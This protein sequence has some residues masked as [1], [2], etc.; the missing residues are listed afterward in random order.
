MALV[1]DPQSGRL[2]A[3][4]WGVAAHEGPGVSLFDG[5]CEAGDLRGCVEKAEALFYGRGVA[6]DQARAMELN[7]RTCDGG[8]ARGCNEWAWWRAEEGQELDL[9][10]KLAQK[11]VSIKPK[12]AYLDTLAYVHL[13]R[14]ELDQA[15]QQIRRVLELEPDTEVYK[16]RLEEILAAGR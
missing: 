16:K 1:F 2:N 7:R 14:G 4:L 13:K 10:L 12:A 5:V 15:E 9:A 3:Q 11:A 6:Q 8:W